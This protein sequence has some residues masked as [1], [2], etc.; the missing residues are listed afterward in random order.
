MVGAPEAGSQDQWS[1]G[2]RNP[3]AQ[4]GG[5][6]GPVSH[7][8]R[9]LV[10]C[11]SVMGA[12]LLSAAGTA[13]S[14]NATPSLQAPDARM[15]APIGHRQPRRSDLP[16]DAQRDEQFDL[17]LAQAQA[18][19]QPP[20]R[21]A[22]AG[23]VPTIDVRKSCEISVKD[24]GPIFGSNIGSSLESC[25]KQEQEARQQ[26]TNSWTKYPSVDRQRCI[27]PTGYLP[28]YVEWLTCLEMY[29]DVRNLNN[30]TTR[31]GAGSR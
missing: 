24:I 26:M 3:A 16:P 14:Q 7:R 17:P 23:S 10:L 19:N 30:A 15:Q 18:K 12:S 21:R 2:R 11:M 9:H 25:V 5:R 28:S 22:Q 27:N 8:L 31:S 29:R 1:S 20:D 13:V 6:A 4:C